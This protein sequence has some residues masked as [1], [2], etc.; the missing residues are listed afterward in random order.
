[1]T[2]VLTPS[3][4]IKAIRARGACERCGKTERLHAHHIDRDKANNTLDNGECLCVWCHDAE[5]GGTGKIVAYDE[6]GRAAGK[7]P[8]SAEHIEKLRLNA[9]INTEAQ[10]DVPLTAEHKANIS[11]ALKTSEKFKAANEAKVGVPMSEE[12]KVKLRGRVP[13]NKG[14]SDLQV[15]WNKGLRKSTSN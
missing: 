3:Q 7:L 9:A 13:A 6:A 15:P 8:K 2:E 4:W 11:E 14:R 1:M 5:H 10:R 12:T